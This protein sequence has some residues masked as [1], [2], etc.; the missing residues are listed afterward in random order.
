MEVVDEKYITIEDVAKH[1]SVSISTV[2]SWMR[3][4]I[5]PA[6]KIANV[7]RFKLS[8]VDAALKNYSKAKEIEG[9]KKDPRQLELDFN[10]DKDL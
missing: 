9:Q 8:D 7:Y 1:Y 3:A 2:R 5:I 10:P 6:L 4:D